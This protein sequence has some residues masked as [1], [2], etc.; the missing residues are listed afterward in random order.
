[1]PLPYAEQPCLV[2]HQQARQAFPAGILHHK[3][4][5][6]MARSMKTKFDPNLVQA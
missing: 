6:K 5:S 1:M 4:V 3:E 2:T